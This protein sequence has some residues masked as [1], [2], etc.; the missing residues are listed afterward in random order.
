MKNLWLYAKI[1]TPDSRAFLE[2]LARPDDAVVCLQDGVY[3]LHQ[4]G[5]RLPCPVAAVAADL[6]ARGLSVDCPQLDYAVLAER[7]MQAERVITI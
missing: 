5:A 4:G 7:I 1:P 2:R 3:L 6:A